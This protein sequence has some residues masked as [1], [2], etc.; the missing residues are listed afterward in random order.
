MGTNRHIDCRSRRC[1]HRSSG[2][3]RHRPIRRRPGCQLPRCHFRGG[4]RLRD[5]IR[6][7]RRTW[8]L[9]PS[10]SRTQCFGLSTKHQTW[11]CDTTLVPPVFLMRCNPQRPT[12]FLSFS[13]QSA[14]L[15]SPSFGRC[16]L[17]LHSPCSPWLQSACLGFR[18][19]C[20]ESHSTAI[21]VF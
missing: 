8:P 7:T 1:V 4:N 9:H 16:R 17:S 14:P 10:T 11:F 3:R 19:S 18:Q 5:A 2:H 21:S 12:R 15:T 6:F 20:S 13:F